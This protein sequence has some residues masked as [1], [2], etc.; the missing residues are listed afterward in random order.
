MNPN[1]NQETKFKPYIPAG[2]SMPEFT[3]TAIILGC[4]LAVVFG[5]A[6]AYIGLKAGITI[7]ASIPASVISM[8]VLRLILKRDSILENNMVQTVASAGESVAA[9]CIFTLPALFMWAAEWGTEKPSLLLVFLIA[10][11]G[12]LI[13]TVFMIPLRKA[14]IV[15]EHGVLPYPEGTACAEVL[16]AGEQGGSDANLVFAGLGIAG[17]YKLLTSDGLNLFKSSVTRDIPVFKGAGFGI[18]ATPALLGVGFICGPKIGA[19]MFAGS[20]LSWFVLM[21]VI[22][23]FGGDSI[24]A[25][26]KLPISQMTGQ[27]MWSNYIRYIGAGTVATGGIIGIVKTMPMIVETVK[28]SIGIVKD[29]D[30]QKSILRTDK[31]MSIISIV[32]ISI[33]LLL[34]VGFLPQIPVNWVGVLIIAV[35]GFFFTTVSSR[36]VGIVGASNNPSSGITIATLLIASFILK[37]TGTVG[38]E[39]MVT[40]IVIG[41]FICVIASMAADTSQD[42]K[43]GYIVGSTPRNQQ[44]GMFFGVATA[45]ISAGLILYLLNEAWGYGSVQLPAPQATLMKLVVEGFMG[46]TLPWNLV[47]MGAFIAVVCELLGVSTMAFAIGLYLPIG[48]NACIL[49]GGIIKYIFEKRNLPKEKKEVLGKRGLLFSSGLIAGEGLIGVL[50]AVAAVVSINGTTVSDM[51]NIMGPGAEDSLLHGYG[52]FVFF[53]ALIILFFAF[54][55]FKKS[56]KQ[57]VA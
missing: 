14:L 12:G 50:L 42:L 53:A 47:I 8:G 21:P 52:T 16:M 48:T 44:I 34:F 55:M 13:G 51:I 41:G 10:L 54:T 57:E 28:D 40:S 11:I 17:L 23:F 45:A 46:G 56:K 9:G 2:K 32:V 31:D 15:K 38:Q 35:F 30:R 18:E 26:G 25:P 37:M 19:V 49:V 22:S 1:N 29:K 7:A 20:V 24:V 39:G 33:T 4:I 6:N 43:T 3:P 36:I 5:A 27:D